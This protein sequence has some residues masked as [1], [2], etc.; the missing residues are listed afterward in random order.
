MQFLFLFGFLSFLSWAFV[1]CSENWH[2]KMNFKM[3]KY[4]LKPINHH[5]FNA[6]KYRL[7]IILSILGGINNFRP[8]MKKIFMDS[9]NSKWP[10]HNL[11]FSFRKEHGCLYLPACDSH[12]QL[13]KPVPN[14]NKTPLLLFLISNK[15]QALPRSQGQLANQSYFEKAF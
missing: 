8:R 10:P 5:E 12:K 11:P 14:Q 1:S 9:G 13:W 4:Q 7:A 6:Y 15:S 3:E 2:G